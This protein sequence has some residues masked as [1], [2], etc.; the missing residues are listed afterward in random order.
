MPDDT[1]AIAA[2][3]VPR[4]ILLA[5]DDCLAALRRISRESR[6]EESREQAHDALT[7]AALFDELRRAGL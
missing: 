6:D 2:P 4:C 5:L 7:R 3:G 1:A